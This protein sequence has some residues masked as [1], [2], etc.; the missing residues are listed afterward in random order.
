MGTP[1]CMA[2]HDD[3]ALMVEHD[4]E[5]D[6]PE[7]IEVP[8]MAFIIRAHEV[9]TCFKTP[10][11]AIRFRPVASDAEALEWFDIEKETRP[12]ERRH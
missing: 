3:L 5:L 10:R 2:T 1:F 4:V 7:P 9:A 12:W 11:T 8:V 6:I